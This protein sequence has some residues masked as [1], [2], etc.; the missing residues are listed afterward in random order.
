MWFPAQLRPGEIASDLD[1]GGD[2]VT[3]REVEVR[4]HGSLLGRTADW[5]RDP[6]AG[7]NLE[8]LLSRSTLRK[9][10]DTEGK[11]RNRS[12]RMFIAISHAD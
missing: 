2:L 7:T 1:L 10:N 3:D 4:S 5:C 11:D 6:R 12:K 9:C 8:S